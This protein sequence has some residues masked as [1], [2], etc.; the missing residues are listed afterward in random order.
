MNQKVCIK[1]GQL[2]ILLWEF[3]SLFFN[4]GINSTGIMGDIQYLE[5]ASWDIADNLKKRGLKSI[6][7]EEAVACC[8]C[9]K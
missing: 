3:D 9:L 8:L 7:G 5:E 6:I 4:D 1:V 2:N